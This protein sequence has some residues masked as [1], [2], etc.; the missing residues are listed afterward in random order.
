MLC[1]DELNQLPGLIGRLKGELLLEFF[2]D[3]QENVSV[4][5]F[6]Q[7]ISGFHVDAAFYSLFSLLL[8]QTLEPVLHCVLRSPTQTL[9]DT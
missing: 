7:L 1:S 5:V 3:L 2:E 4:D 9:R 6:S 8:H